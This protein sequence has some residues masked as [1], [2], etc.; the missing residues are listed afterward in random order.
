MGNSGFDKLK[1]LV[2]VGIDPKTSIESLFSHREDKGDLLD[3][4]IIFKINLSSESRHLIWR[5]LAVFSEKVKSAWLPNDRPQPPVIEDFLNIKTED[6]EAMST[7]S[8]IQ[9]MLLEKLFAGP[10]SH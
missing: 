7:F 6:L 10:Q 5:T 1:S 8:P 9:R 4:H 3:Q 2:E